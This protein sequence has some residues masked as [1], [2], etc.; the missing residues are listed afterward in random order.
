MARKLELAGTVQNLSDG[1][2]EIFA[3]GGKKTLDTYVTLLEGGS[4]LSRVDTI[5][6]TFKKTVNT[7]N[8]FSILY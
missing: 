2:V 5:E 1:T 8:D 3:Q 7:Y 4:V 6:T